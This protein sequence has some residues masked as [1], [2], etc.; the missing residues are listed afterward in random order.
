MT[1][2]TGFECECETD[3]HRLLIKS[4]IDYP[5]ILIVNVKRLITVYCIE[6]G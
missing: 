6:Q 5:F 4:G 2:Q 1:M 3:V